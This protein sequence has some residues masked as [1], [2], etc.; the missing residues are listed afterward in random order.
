MRNCD[1]AGQIIVLNDQGGGVLNVSIDKTSTLRA[2]DHG[3][4]PVIV[5]EPRSQDGVPRVVNR[6]VSP[7]LNTAGGA[8]TTMRVHR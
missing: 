8:E 2:Q 3:H 7:T 1:K 4:P 6:D 5:F